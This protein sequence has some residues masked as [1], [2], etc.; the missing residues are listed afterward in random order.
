MPF[1]GGLLERTRY[2]QGRS[3]F[4]VMFFWSAA[5]WA[6]LFFMRTLRGYLRHARARPR[7]KHDFMK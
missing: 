6:A 3:I 4:M 1:F 7:T 5:Y 2:E